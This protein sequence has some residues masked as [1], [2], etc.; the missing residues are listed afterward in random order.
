[1]D[2]HQER[3]YDSVR[4][5]NQGADGLQTMDHGQGLHPLHGDKS[6]YQ[7]EDTPI[8]YSVGSPPPQAAALA[9][10]NYWQHAAA[11]AATAAAAAEKPKRI[12][13]LRRP[14]FFL[15]VSN[16]VLAVALV[17]VGVVPS[18]LAKNGATCFVAPV[19]SGAVESARTSS[20]QPGVR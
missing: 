7:Y 9:A 4:G 17:I 20:V 13:G 12:C 10:A 15:L 2:A 5:R 8:A 6:T 18:Q 16:I 11:A 3:H 14:T 1:M 19:T